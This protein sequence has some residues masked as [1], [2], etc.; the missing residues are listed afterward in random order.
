MSLTSKRLVSRGILATLLLL[1]TFTTIRVVLDVRH[2]AWI[3]YTEADINRVASWVEVFHDEHG[4][5]PQLLS[6]LL[7]DP[8]F[9]GIEFLHYVLVGHPDR[10]WEYYPLTNGFSLIVQRPEAFLCDAERIER[11]YESGETS[12]PKTTD[13]SNQ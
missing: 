1:I 11:T 2:K 3:E 10:R 8:D 5:Y 12:R 7:E 9:S 13:L 6:E 4:R